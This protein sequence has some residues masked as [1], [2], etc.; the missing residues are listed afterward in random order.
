VLSG[1]F[2]IINGGGLLIGAR[3]WRIWS[4]Y[5]VQILIYLIYI[6]YTRRRVESCL[7]M[8]HP[9]PTDPTPIL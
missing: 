5:K 9:T 4:L 7:L 2:R 1:A 6:H 3:N 8:Q